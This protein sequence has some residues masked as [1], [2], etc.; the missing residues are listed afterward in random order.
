[1]K[2]GSRRAKGRRLQVQVAETLARAFKLTI[3]AETPTKPGKRNGVW[4]IGEGELYPSQAARELGL[5]EGQ[6]SPD[7][8]VR[9]S[10]QLGADV[11]LLSPRARDLVSWCDLP[12]WIECKNMEGGWDLGKAFW[13]GKVP[14]GLLAA[15]NQANRGAKATFRPLV[16]VARNF[17]PAVA[18]ADWLEEMLVAVETVQGPCVTLGGGLCAVPFETVVRG[19]KGE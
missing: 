16:I 4:W 2:H 5:V 12:L 9:L 19:L 1:M 18:V 14:A 11:A 15:W 7:L 6:W 13:E 3:L 17:W 10:A 8:K